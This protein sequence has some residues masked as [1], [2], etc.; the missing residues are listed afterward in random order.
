MHAATYLDGAVLPKLDGLAAP[1]GG[2]RVLL[3]GAA[4]PM[5]ELPRLAESLSCSTLPRAVLAKGESGLPLSLALRADPRTSESAGLQGDDS[6]TEAAFSMPSPVCAVAPNG[7]SCSG[8]CRIR[9]HFT[10]EDATF[11]LSHAVS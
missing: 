10:E 1:A 4:A 2:W 7:S 3:R 5:A 11:T 9:P 6:T 8:W